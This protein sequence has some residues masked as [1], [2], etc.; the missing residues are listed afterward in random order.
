MKVT[1]IFTCFNRKGQSVRCVERLY[2]GNP[3]VQCNFIVVDDGSTDGT[4]TALTSLSV[5][6]IVISGTGQLYWAGGMRKG[7]EAYLAQPEPSDYCLL[8]NDDVLFYDQI[9]LSMIHMSQKK[10][11]AVIVG[12]TCD[13]DGNLTYGGMKLIIPRKKDIY[14]QV[15]PQ[16]GGI[17]CDTFNCNCVLLPDFVLRTVGNFDSAYTHGLADLDYGLTLKAR[18][19]PMY[20]SE[21]Y[22]GECEK[23]S[24]LGTWQD[25]SLS[26]WERFKKKEMPKGA[27]FRE[28]FHFMKKHFGLLAAIRYSAT[29]YLKIILRK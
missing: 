8:V 20:S 29:P 28:W 25:T 24:Q 3:E 21:K 2:S 22:I 17:L 16:K 1:V 10:A 23:N 13:K 26:R 12:A 19:I 18:H 7:I 11:N 4:Q 15:V 9:L 14:R 6:M 27:P 5:P